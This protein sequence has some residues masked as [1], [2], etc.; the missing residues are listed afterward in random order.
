M[1]V[2]NFLKDAKLISYDK[3]FL[4]K[5]YDEID[6]ILEMDALTLNNMLDT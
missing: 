5:G 3:K 4:N 2:T 1:D 6:Q